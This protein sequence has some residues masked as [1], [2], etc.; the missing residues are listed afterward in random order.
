MGDSSEVP[1]TIHPHFKLV[2]TAKPGRLLLTG[3]L[4]FPNRTGKVKVRL[5]RPAITY[6]SKGHRIIDPVT[7]VS[8]SLWPCTS[9]FLTANLTPLK[10]CC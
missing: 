10:A 3:V 5:M 6:L 9:T 2:N 1:L 4:H 8:N 7:F